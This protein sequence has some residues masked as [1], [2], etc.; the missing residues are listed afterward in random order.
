MILR[1][2]CNKLKGYFILKDSVLRHIPVMQ[3]SRQFEC[4][5]NQ[6]LNNMAVE[7][8]LFHLTI[9]PEQ[10]ATSYSETALLSNKSKCAKVIF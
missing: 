2:T 1:D 5:M 6:L 4:N 8:L 10:L 3:D 7:S 9:A